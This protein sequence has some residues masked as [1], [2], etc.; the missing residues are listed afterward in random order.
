[1]K[2][3]IEKI[4]ENL[5]QSLDNLDI[6]FTDQIKEL[7]QNLS[8][9]FKEFDQSIKTLTENIEEQINLNSRNIKN[10]NKEFEIFQQN[11]EE[12]LNAHKEINTELIQEFDKQFNKDKRKLEEELASIQRE[13]DVL[14]ISYTVNEKQLLEKIEAMILSEIS[15]VCSDKEREILMN[16]W[17]KDLKEIV[18]DFEKLKKMNPKEFTLKIGEITDTIELFKQK[19]VK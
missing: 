9:R 15:N 17:M 1:M 19:I 4:D 5:K 11:L 12:Q 10:L 13:Q 8:N 18:N 14:K 6:K 7:N 16:I 2:E 3:K